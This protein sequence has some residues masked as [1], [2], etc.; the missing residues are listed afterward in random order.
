MKNFQLKSSIKLSLTKKMKEK[1]TTPRA[2]G[3]F[4]SEDYQNSLMRLVTG[5]EG[6]VGEG[7]FFKVYLIID[8]QDGVIADFKYQCFGSVILIAIAE[9]LAELS[10]RKNYLQASRI[11]Y[12]LIDRQLRDQ[13]DRVSIQSQD[14]S[15]ANFILS[16][17]Y[18]AL[19]LCDDIPLKEDQIPPPNPIELKNG[20]TYQYPNFLDLT[21][22]EKFKVLEEVIAQDIRPYVQLDQGDVEVKKIEGYQITIGYK[23]SCTTCFSATGS[24]LNAIAQILR[25]KVNPNIEVIPDLSSLGTGS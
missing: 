5:E 10:I 20:E 18:E 2:A 22:T 3:R 6:S 25:A 1:I 15:K 8:E 24:T 7:Q 23:G 21:H 17:F 16:A 19:N 12:E 11:S 14:F 4:F 9:C 13:P